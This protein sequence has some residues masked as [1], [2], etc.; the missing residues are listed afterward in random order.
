MSMVE[1][2]S[3]QQ[4]PH[5]IHRAVIEKRGV[6]CRLL[7]R[8]TEV[9]D[10]R[11]L[12]CA[13]HEPQSKRVGM[14]GT[15]DVVMHDA[16]VPQSLEDAPHACFV[17]GDVFEKPLGDDQIEGAFDLIADRLHDERVVDLVALRPLLDVESHIRESAMLGKHGPI[18]P[19]DLQNPHGAARQAGLD[20]PHQLG[21]RVLK[22]AEARESR[23]EPPAQAI[24]GLDE[25]GDPQMNSP[26]PVGP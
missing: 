11:P 16:P 1:S 14:V 3:L 20:P 6:A 26:L 12:Q 21:S 13:P 19:A 4:V 9:S 7:V 23:V 18:H 22:G 15:G 25:L 5:P 10:Q 8:G 24:V 17:V 2:R